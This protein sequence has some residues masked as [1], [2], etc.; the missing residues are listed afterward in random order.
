MLTVSGVCEKLVLFGKYTPECEG[1]VLNFVWADSRTSFLFFSKE[2]AAITFSGIGRNQV[3][4]DADTAVQ[5]I[6]I[7]IFGFKGKSDNIPSVGSCRF[8]NPYN[9]S[10]II[11]CHADTPSGAFDANFVTDGGE[12]KIAPPSIVNEMNKLF[13]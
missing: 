6:D 7:V 5:P 3:K 2:G 8:T 9:G 13:R 4:P 11:N 12:P 1:K 10:G